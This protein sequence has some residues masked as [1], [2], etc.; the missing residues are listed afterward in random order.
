MAQQVGDP[1]FSLLWL[2]MLLWHGFAPWP[3]NFHMMQVWPKNFLKI[4][5]VRIYQHWLYIYNYIDNLYSTY[6]FSYLNIHT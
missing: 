5:I 3:G 1:V 4:N 6:I 2:R